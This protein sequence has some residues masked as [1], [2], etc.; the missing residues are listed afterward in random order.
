MAIPG[1]D[2]QEY[3]PSWFHSLLTKK[4]Q[5]AY[6]RLQRGEKVR[7]IIECPPRHGKTR[8][9]AELFPAWVMG[10]S[11]IPIISCSY[12]FEL[13]VTTGGNTKDVITDP[14]YQAIFPD[15]KLR[16]DMTAKDNWATT[17]GAKYLGTGVGGGITGKGFKC[18]S[19][20]SLVE[21]TRGAMPVSDIKPGDKVL[22]Y[23]HDINTRE[24]TTVRAVAASISDKRIVRVG[25]LKATEDHRV[26]TKYKG[27][28]EAQ[29]LQ[30]DDII[31]SNVWRSVREENLRGEAHSIE[32]P[33]NYDYVVDIQTDTGNFFADGILVHNCGIVDDP[34]KNRQ[35][36]DSATTREM[37]WS[38]WKSTFYTRQEGNSAIIVIATRWHLD[39]LIG[40]LL[41]QQEDNEAAGLPEGSYD[42]WEVIKFP[43]IAEEDEYDPEG[44]LLRRAGEPLFPEKFTINDLISIKNSISD[45][46]EWSSLYQQNP[47]LTEN[48]E[49][50][51]TYF[52]YFS[53]ADIMNKDLRVY[54]TVDPAIGQKQTS[55]N[56]SI[57]VVGK[58]TA[59]SDWYHLEENTAHLDPLQIIE[60]LFF[61]K[62]K[63]GHKLAKVG[64]ESYVYQKSLIYYLTEEM[65]RRQVFFDVVELKGKGSKEERI[66]GLIPL[67][68]SGV[69]HHRHS[70]TELERELL[71]FPKGRHDDRADA[72]SMMNLLI[73]NTK[74]SRT[75][76]QWKPSL[77]RY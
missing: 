6:E 36:A 32:A 61:L 30:E 67:Y 38:W 51:S 77:K 40:K 17:K 62:A 26:F 55:D 50:R 60:Y 18:L 23:N 39:D 54:V 71:Q 15:V 14:L 22:G 44:R 41:Q 68:K 16:P 31:L 37:V 28:V 25:N 66:R 27:Y 45:P 10:K 46:Y 58:E 2:G 8:T 20:D 59:H 47:I 72:L 73:E 1:R 35:E 65:R 12:S 69:I 74:T 56:T 49:F 9:A 52:R 24:W 48:A 34:F 7:L 29:H 70:D 3:V 33:Y 4:L 21:S 64:I 75:A 11:P 57:Q 42:K 19:P 5:E 53:E 43:A 13:A 63:Y 76:R